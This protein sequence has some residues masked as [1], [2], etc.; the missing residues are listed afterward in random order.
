M[1]TP[2]VL[3]S[4]PLLYPLLLCV[5]FAHVWSTCP[6]W[7]DMCGVCAPCCCGQRVRGAE[8]P[9]RTGSRAVAAERRPAGWC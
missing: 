8:A 5:A 6:V 3:A 4:L 9:S 1:S 7:T 2:W